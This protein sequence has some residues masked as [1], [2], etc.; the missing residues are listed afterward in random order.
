MRAP[1]LGGLLNDVPARGVTGASCV[2]VCPLLQQ[3]AHSPGAR[4][5][6][7]SNRRNSVKA[8]EHL[9]I[10]FLYDSNKWHL[11]A[12][13]LA[14]WNQGLLEEAQ[15]CWPAVVPSQSD[16]QMER[17]SKWYRNKFFSISTLFYNISF[18]IPKALACVN[19]RSH[20]ETICFAKYVKDFK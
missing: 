15:R 5:I 11:H 16:C 19:Y 8:G 14:H 4:A 13:V 3:T 7:C 10:D 17:L 18:I 2:G 9:Q 1:G 20:F 6:L 12:S